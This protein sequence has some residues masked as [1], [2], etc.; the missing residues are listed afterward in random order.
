VLAAFALL[1]TYF[2]DKILALKRCQ[3]PVRQ[4]SQSTERVVVFMNVLVPVQCVFSGVLFYDLQYPAYAL[5]CVSIWGAYALLPLNRWLRIERDAAAEDGGT[6]DVAFWSNMGKVGGKGRAP[7]RRDR[8]G[9]KPPRDEEDHARQAAS[10][11]FRSKL[12]N[13][14]ESELGKDRLDIYYPPMP[15]TASEKTIAMIVEG[16]K[17]PHMITPGNPDLLRGQ[18]EHTGGRARV[19]PPFAKKEVAVASEIA[20][21]PAARK[22]V[23]I[24]ARMKRSAG[25]EKVTQKVSPAETPVSGAATGTPRASEKPTTPRSSPRLPAKPAEPKPKRAGTASRVSPLRS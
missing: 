23:S 20:A 21:E 14:P 13:V 4:G 5:A 15:I 12:L 18:K 17:L 3:K 25:L 8:R 1:V 7:G 16:Y 11:R 9:L 10:R 2:T 24:A 6:G 19:G 22:G